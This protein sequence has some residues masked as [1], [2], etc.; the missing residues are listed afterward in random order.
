MFKLTKSLF[1][2]MCMS[3]I[4]AMSYM[5]VPA[6]SHADELT[7]TTVEPTRTINLVYDD[8]TSMIQSDSSHKFVD[9]WCQAKYAVEVFAAMLGETDT[10]NVYVMSDYNH[11]I[12]LSGSDGSDSCVKKVH[13]MVTDAGNT[14][15]A[16]VEKAM[17]DLKKSDADEKWLVVLT[18][19]KFQGKDKSGV[20]AFFSNKPDDIKVMFLGM[21]PD[22]GAIKGNNDKQIFFKKAKNNTDILNN[23][24]DIGQ[25]VFNRAK[26]PVDGNGQISFDVPMKEL[27]VFAQGKQIGVKDISNN[28]QT[29]NSTQS[30]TVRYT[31]SKNA[32]KNKSTHFDVSKIKEDSSLWGVVSTFKGKFKEGK[33]AIGIDGKE[34]LKTMEVYYK[35]DVDVDAFLK[36]K[37]TGK[38]VK[39]NDL[40]AGDYII[41]FALVKSGTKK[42]VNSKLL[43]N[44]DYEAEVTSN[45]TKQDQIYKPG[46]EVSIGE[47]DLH[48]DARATYLDKYTVTTSLDK[49]IFKNKTVGFTVANDPNR[50]VKGGKLTTDE[51]MQVK[52]TLDGNDFT[53]EQWA[54]LDEKNVKVFP[55]DEPE[56][57]IGDFKVEKSGDTGVLNVSPTLPEKLSGTVYH[58]LNLDVSYKQQMP[59]KGVWKGSGQ[60]AMN[61]GDDRSIFEKYRD[62]IIRGLLMLL[63]LLLLFGY[64]FK[65]RLPRNLKSSPTITAVPTAIGY[66]GGSF[67][68]K[69]TR[70]TLSRFLPY[71][72]E[73]GTIRF[74]PKTVR[75]IPALKVKGAGGRKM[76]IMN[77]QSYAGKEHISFNGN[78]VQEGTKKPLKVGGGLLVEV[79]TA[80]RRY[81]CQTN[82]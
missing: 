6:V 62:W 77:T 56:F 32:S 46:D 13:N 52:C 36:D 15:F 76:F 25:T 31:E 48:I 65:K 71:V 72:P 81:S 23:L 11:P 64:I 73:K 26:L 8:S 60:L 9:T 47:G 50:A 21:G 66:T 67:H 43:G 19:G 51:P 18:D 10:L 69:Y 14:P 44:I 82:Q 12:K 24:T 74:V 33:Y 70:D 42:K 2:V 7:G 79:A 55:A 54:Q 29:A 5:Y 68:G 59:D 34:N 63:A 1:L 17:S 16:S 78:P 58:D 61:L 39:G 57:D 75:G 28:K 37:K 35:P 3:L 4:M 27:V 41:D 20:D 80:G 38:R 40:K 30:T 53:D 22:A 45:G 49:S